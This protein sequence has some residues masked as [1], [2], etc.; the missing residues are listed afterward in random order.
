VPFSYFEIDP[1]KESLFNAGFSDIRIAVV[2]VEKEI[3]DA[4]A[5][6][7]GLVFGNPLINEIQARGGV[8]PEQI[9]DTLTTAL[10]RE[11]GADPGR[12]SL[13]AIV[14]EVTKP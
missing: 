3:S 2:T 8:D 9:A 13:Q 14:F 12:M 6:A 10:R 4:A 11:F 1:I 7:R 5:F